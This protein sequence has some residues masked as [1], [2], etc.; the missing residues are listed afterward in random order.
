MLVICAAELATVSFKEEADYNK[1]EN[2]AC[3]IC[4]MLPFTFPF[5]IDHE[6]VKHFVKSYETSSLCSGRNIIV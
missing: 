4:V 3:E 2:V 6:F 5:K 1:I